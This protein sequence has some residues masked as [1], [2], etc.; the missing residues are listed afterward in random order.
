MTLIMTLTLTGATTFV[1]GLLP[2]YSQIG[3]WA[4]LTLI[5]LRFLQGVARVASGAVAC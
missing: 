1:I 2:V 5:I 4:P 3:I